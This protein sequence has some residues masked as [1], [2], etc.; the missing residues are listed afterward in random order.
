MSSNE[1]RTQRVRAGGRSEVVRQTVAATVLEMLREGNA[2]FSVV[3]VAQRAGIHRSTVYRWWPTRIELVK[4][5]L[6]LHTA[7]LVVPDTGD[8]DSDVRTLTRELAEFF[9]DPVEAAM[10]AVLASDVNSEVADIQRAHWGP[11]VHDLSEVV[12]RAKARGE[13]RD[14]VNPRFVLEMIV[15]PLLLTTTFGRRAVDQDA[16]DAIAD[17][18]TRAF[19][20]A[21]QVP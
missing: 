17:V 4:E 2:A 21:G 14:A 1:P 15:G 5:A 18:I 10:N 12:D 11:I 19:G 6:T 9:S 16:I 7:R 3:D 20:T 8:W 13:V